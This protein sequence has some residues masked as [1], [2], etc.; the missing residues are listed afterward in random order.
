MHI[1]V[2]STVVLSGHLQNYSCICKR[3]CWLCTLFLKRS[4]IL[5]HICLPIKF[6]WHDCDFFDY[7]AKCEVKCGLWTLFPELNT[8]F[9]RWLNILTNQIVLLHKEVSPILVHRLPTVEQ[10][11]FPG[12]HGTPIWLRPGVWGYVYTC[13][14]PESWVNSCCRVAIVII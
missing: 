10:F 2:L 7:G 12:L 13:L 11:V 5:L 14:S 4:V 6:W 9:K 8:C 3:A 1:L